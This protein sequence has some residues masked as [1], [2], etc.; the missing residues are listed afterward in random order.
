MENI[1]NNPLHTAKLLR[2]SSDSLF[3]LD[4]EGICRELALNVTPPAFVSEE[5]LLGKNIFQLLPKETAGEMKHEFEQVVAYRCSSS[6]DYKL[7]VGCTTY[8]IE[9]AMHPYGEMVV[10]LCND[11]TDKTRQSLQLERK[12][13]Q[14]YEVQKAASIGMW[15]Y[16]RKQNFFTYQ[17]QTGVLCRDRAQTIGYESYRR[18]IVP[19]DLQG[20][21][22]HMMAYVE[23]NLEPCTDYRLCVEGEVYYMHLKAYSREELS[24]GNVIVEGY[25]QNITEIQRNRNDINLLTHAINNS[26]EDIF[27]ARSDGQLLF[28]NRKFRQHHHIPHTTDI[29]TLHFSDL[30]SSPNNPEVWA[31]LMKNIRRDT[32][33][34]TF[35]VHHPIQDDPSI[36]AYEGN[37]YWVT[38]D[39][40]EE[41]L[42][43]FGR[44]ISQRIRNKQQLERMHRELEVAKE[45]AEDSDRLKSAFLANMSHEIRTPLNAIV[46][47]SRLIAESHDEADRKAY[48][49]IVESN[50]RRL[51]SLIDEILDLSKIEANMEKFNFSPVRLNTLFT[52]IYE[53]HRLRC[54]QEVKLVCDVDPDAETMIETDKNRLY[55]AISN[56]IGNA[57]KFTKKGHIT[58]GYQPSEERIDFFVRDTGVGIAP[59]EI[60]HVFDRFVKTNDFIQG[61]GLGLSLSKTLIERLGGEISVTSQVG[62]GTE[63]RFYL[64]RSCR[65]GTIQ[66][67]P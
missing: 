53:T 47:F 31:N 30:T 37:A 34:N 6:K 40:G 32:E 52:E 1:L 2:L 66:Q 25:V 10:W 44:D 56:L 50:N 3:L 4:R 14:L 46:G 39:E 7:T 55:Q 17:G 26:T 28:A 33:N 20:F 60:G 16:N 15:K 35:I 38:S 64:P 58:Y 24:D 63:F 59:E 43:A 9:C 67:K 57:F 62:Q 8:Y 48:Y 5:S 18:M 22:R 11:I 27:A 45:K 49:Q 61:T 21:D 19:E 65:N 36:L 51:L 54:P 13:R 42:W 41:V 29:T 12:S 23:G